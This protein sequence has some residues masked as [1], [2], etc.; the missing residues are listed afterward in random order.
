MLQCELDAHTNKLKRTFAGLVYNLQRHIEENSKIDEIIT[1]LKLFDDEFGQLLINC[2][3]MEEVF[4]KLHPHL[5]FF[6]FEIIKLLTKNLGSTSNKKKLK[7]YKKMFEC[8]AKQRVCECP[9]DAFGN[10]KES[11]KT[12][13]I[14]LDKNIRK[15]E[16]NELQQLIHEICRIL[17]LKLRLLHIDKGCVQL[18]FRVLHDV[19]KI[20]ISMENHQALK[21]LCVLTIQY[22]NEVILQISTP[23]LADKANGG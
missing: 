3:S 6:D 14:K 23:L 18:S 16:L 11:E 22:G 7:K 8:F 10:H 12:F 21:D 9:S 19:D 2:S 20:V 4:T 1:V 5:S 17:N 15:L 13:I